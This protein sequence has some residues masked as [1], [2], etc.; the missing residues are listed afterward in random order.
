MKRIF[1]LLFL[2]LSSCTHYP[3][4]IHEAAELNASSKVNLN[5]IQE[6]LTELRGVSNVEHKKTFPEDIEQLK[7]EN[8]LKGIDLVT[9]EIDLE[10]Q[11]RKTTFSFSIEQCLQA[12]NRFVFY[13]YN[14]P[15]GMH[16][17]PDA[18][19]KKSLELKDFLSRNCGLEPVVAQLQVVS[20]YCPELV[21]VKDVK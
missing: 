10:Y 17:L 12:P 11:S 1:T 21:K 8:K 4:A 6:T 18:V 16:Y 15:T 19:K 9:G 5:C 13:M 2:S 14:P 20:S 7:Q 3:P